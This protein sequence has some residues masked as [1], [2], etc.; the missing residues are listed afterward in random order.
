MA[1]CAEQVEPD[2]TKAL[3]QESNN[4]SRYD[5]RVPVCC[6]VRPEHGSVKD[7]ETKRTTNRLHGNKMKQKLEKKNEPPPPATLA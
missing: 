2:G 4:T 5:K 7:V 1:F 6:E 3:Y